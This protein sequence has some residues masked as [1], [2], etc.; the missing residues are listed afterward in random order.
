MGGKDSVLKWRDAGLCKKDK[1][2]FTQEGYV[3]LGDL[4]FNA[5]V[6]DHNSRK[7]IL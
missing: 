1:L 6:E 5:I 4:L 3:L 7:E 2:H